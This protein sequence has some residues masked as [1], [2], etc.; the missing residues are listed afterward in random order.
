MLD[1][2]W[3]EALVRRDDKHRKVDA[4]RAGEHGFDEFL[5]TRHVHHAGTLPRGSASQ[6][7]KP[8][9]DGESPPLFLRQTVGVHAGEGADQRRFSVVDVTGGCR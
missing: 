3:H 4:A 6:Q 2:L 5:V 8:Q 9:L 1:R 7:P